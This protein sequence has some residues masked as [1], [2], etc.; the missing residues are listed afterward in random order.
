MLAPA[1][2]QQ[3]RVS[4][5]FRQ[6]TSTPRTPQIS[7]RSFCISFSTCTWLRLSCGTSYGFSLFLDSVKAS[8]TMSS[9]DCMDSV[10]GQPLSQRFGGAGPTIV[11]VLVHGII[12]LIVVLIVIGELIVGR[13]VERRGR[14]WVEEMSGESKV[15]V[16]SV[17]LR[18][19][20]SHDMRHPR[21]LR[22]SDRPLFFDLP[23][24]ESPFEGPTPLS[25]SGPCMEE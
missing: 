3:L 21:G 19:G 8:T 25:S 9:S 7:S 6:L 17:T 22:H 23:F 2:I 11:V 18:S 10:E 12:V 24:L 16:S 20:G 1:N 5:V 13:H 15:L 4:G 14:A